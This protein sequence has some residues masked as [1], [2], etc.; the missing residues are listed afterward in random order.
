MNTLNDSQLEV[1]KSCLKG[2]SA[3]SVVLLSN[4]FLVT[5]EVAQFIEA[6]NS[7]WLYI[8]VNNSQGGFE[9]REDL[10]SD[11][12]QVWTLEADD[13]TRQYALRGFTPKGRQLYEKFY[14]YD[15]CGKRKL[16]D[17]VFYFIPRYQGEAGLLMFATE[18]P[19]I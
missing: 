6:T 15:L 7:R 17:F 10:K 1:I 8:G 18:C 2:A 13:Q 11:F 19:A 4:Y 14:D 9:E 16:R 5:E 3:L 12:L